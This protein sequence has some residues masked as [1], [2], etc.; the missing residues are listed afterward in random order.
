M[1]AG[2]ALHFAYELSGF[3]WFAALFGSANEST[4]EHLKLFFWPGL[5]CA[6]VQ[7]AFVKGYANNYWWGKGLAL[8]V[9]TVGVI[10]SFY[11]GDPGDR[12][13]SGDWGVVDGVDTPAVFRPSNQT[14]YFR[15]TLTQGNADSQFT[16]TGAGSSWLP[17]AGDFNPN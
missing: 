14:F 1:V 10:V 7:H 4:W 2:S 16:W 13:V 9:T 11:F 3:N 12:F 5:V 8:L 15:H 17:V 6:L